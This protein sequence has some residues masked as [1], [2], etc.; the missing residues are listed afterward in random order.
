MNLID[1]DIIQFLK[2]D[3]E[4]KTQIKNGDFLKEKQKIESFFS[5][6]LEFCEIRLEIKKQIAV[7]PII[8][9]KDT[10]LKEVV[11]KISKQN[12]FTADIV[13]KTLNKNLDECSEMVNFN[14]NEIDELS[15]KIL[16]NWFGP[17]EYIEGLI[18]IGLMVTNVHIPINLKRYID[19]ARKC[20]AFQQYNAVNALARIILESAMR[21]IAI[22]KKHIILIKNHKQFYKKY[23]PRKLIKKVSKNAL[24]TRI[25]KL[26]YDKLSPQIH[27]L[28]NISDSDVKIELKHTIDIIEELYRINS[29]NV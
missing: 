14:E 2:I 3:E 12:E 16:F 24:K 13:L 22:R 11:K 9:F 1:K 5:K 18:E 4:I 23:P 6:I 28:K 29:V 8:T 27:G 10:D 20:Y 25:E 21:D 26:Y 17:R 7:H 19:E 15:S